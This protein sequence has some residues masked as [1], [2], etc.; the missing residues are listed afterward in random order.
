[1]NN[2]VQILDDQF[3]NIAF[4]ELKQLDKIL[5]KQIKYKR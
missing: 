2:Y 4:E 5:N 3:S 1:M